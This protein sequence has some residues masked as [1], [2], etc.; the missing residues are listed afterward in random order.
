MRAALFVASACA[1]AGCY[2]LAAWVV[3]SKAG[4]VLQA[5]DLRDADAAFRANEGDDRNDFVTPDELAALLA[6]AGLRMG[7]P[8][9]IAWSPGKGLHLSDDLALNYIVTVTS[10]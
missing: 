8:R 9:G 4:R 6:Q 1:L 3:R 2:L 7:S 5:L 10:A